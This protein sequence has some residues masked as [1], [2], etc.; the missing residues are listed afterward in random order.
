MCPSLIGYAEF[1][2]D[3][4]EVAHGLESLRATSGHGGVTVLTI[5]HIIIARTGNNSNYR[6]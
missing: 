2:H 6:S 1:G 3:A 4:V 5:C